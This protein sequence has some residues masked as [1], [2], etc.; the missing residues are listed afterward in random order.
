MRVPGVRFTVRRLMVAVAVLAVALG[1]ERLLIRWTHFRASA[2]R[3]A[4]NHRAEVMGWESCAKLS[5][6][7]VTSLTPTWRGDRTRGE[8]LH[9]NHFVPRARPTDAG[10]AAAFDRE[11]AAIA[12][13]CR[14]MARYHD[15][16]RRK[17]ERAASRPWESI[18]PDPPP[19]LPLEQSHIRDSIY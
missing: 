2:Q 1:T 13:K 18:S 10:Q 3:S 6:E 8:V 4:V 5:D 12:A 17:W 14:A 7:G 16:L 19:P 15:G 11:C 9:F